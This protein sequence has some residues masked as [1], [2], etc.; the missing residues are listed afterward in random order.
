M[1]KLNSVSVV[2]CPPSLFRSHAP[3][4]FCTPAPPRPPRPH[5]ARRTLLLRQHRGPSA[6][7]LCSA[8]AAARPPVLRLCPLRPPP[9]ALLC[10]GRSACTAS[11]VPLRHPRSARAV[12][13]QPLCPRHSSRAAHPTPLRPRR[14]ARA[15]PLHAAQP[16]PIC[17]ACS[18]PSRTS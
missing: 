14:C 5:A 2:V 4:P 18:S 12:S 13:P 8:R 3:L 9:P 16:M 1:H 15:E 7:L 6:R 11:T 10:T 17:C